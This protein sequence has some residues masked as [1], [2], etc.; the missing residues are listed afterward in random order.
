VIQAACRQIREWRDAGLRVPPVAVNLSAR[1]FASDSLVDDFVAAMKQHGVA[2]SDIEVELTESVLMADPDRANEVLQRLHALGVRISIDD[3]GT[4]YSSLS[5]LK[6]F[7]AQTVKIDRSFISGL[8]SDADDVAIIE[9]VIAMAHS[10]GLAVVAEGVETDEQLSALRRL[11]CD[12]AQ[13]YL[14]GRP[15]PAPA[16]AAQLRPMVEQ[17]PGTVRARTA[18]G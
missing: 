5:Y 1:Q 8:P 10:L 13:G 18:A 15:M 4:G 3:F 12:E 7:P 11:G 14:L 6:R 9:A 17:L 2:A 16:L